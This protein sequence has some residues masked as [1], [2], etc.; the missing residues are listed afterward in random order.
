MCSCIDRGIRPTRK[1]QKEEWRK[2]V[3]VVLLLRSRGAQCAPQTE[4]RGLGVEV[5]H[6]RIHRERRV[7]RAGRRVGVVRDTVRAIRIRHQRLGRGRHDQVFARTTRMSLSDA[8]GR[9]DVYDE[10]G[11]RFGIGGSVLLI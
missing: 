9:I 6:T 3:R 4:I 1:D 2:W 5:C 10:R 11:R 7:K 8:P